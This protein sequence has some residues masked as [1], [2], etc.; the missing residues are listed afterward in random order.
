MSSNCQLQFFTKVATN[1]IAAGKAIRPTQTTFMP[2]RHILEGLIVLHEAIH[3]LHQKKLD[4]VLFN[5]TLKR[6]MIKWPFYYKL[7]A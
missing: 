5:T 6:S 1:R 3:E 2:G 7:Y 4:G